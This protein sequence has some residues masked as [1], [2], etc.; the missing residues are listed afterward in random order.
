M[1]EQLENITHEESNKEC[2]CSTDTEEFTFACCP[3]M[4]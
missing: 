2:C 4:Q 1:S 3:E